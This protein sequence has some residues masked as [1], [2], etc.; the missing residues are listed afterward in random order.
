MLAKSLH[1][2]AIATTAVVTTALAAEQRQAPRFDPIPIMLR[3]V[4]DL[5]AVTG[6][7]YPSEGGIAEC[8]QAIRTWSSANFSGGAFTAQQGFSQGEIAAVSFSVAADQFPLRV[9]LAEM[10]FAT[11]SANVTTT[12]HWS[13]MFW[14]GTPATGQLIGT[15]SSDG[16]ILPHLVMPPGTNGTNIQ[17]SVD[18][19]DPEQ[20][21]LQNNGSGIVSVGYRIDKHH[22][23]PGGP[24]G[25]IPT[26][27][28]AFPTT[29]TNGLGA[30]TTNWLFAINCGPFACPAGWKSF[31]QLIS[32]CKPSGDWNI[33]LTY[34][35]LGCAPPT[36]GACCLPSGACTVASPDDCAAQSGTFQG[37]N[38]NCAGVTCL[39]TGNV[40]CCFPATGNC[41]NLSFA[42]CQLAGGVPG[43]I[44]LT[45]T[46]Y[47]CFPTGACCKPDGTCAVMSPGDCALASGLYQG[48]NTTC[49]QVNCP[50]PTGA[51]CFPNNF[52]LLM[53]QADAAAAGASWKGAGTTCADNNFNG[54]ADVCEIPAIPGDIN[55]DGFVNGADL[56][57][58]L[59]SWGPCGGCSGDV[60]GDDLVDGADIAIV[61]GNWTG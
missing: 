12:T 51:A 56:A 41:L 45:C 38:T 59:G 9:D 46:G 52:C 16:K 60:T 43:P 30:P 17:F 58:V 3:D 44:G 55:G 13:V 27:A 22:S 49:G 42:N 61:L 6:D 53:T 34:T 15:F 48:N 7:G 29:D 8:P 1:V 21:I 37:A 26:N 35:G 33:R 50:A 24:C 25:A 20:I 31:N 23:L 40:P 18:P 54:T 47:T 19:G 11:T 57:I 4:I 39:P 14:E 5:P 36:P 2:I 10:I 28:N 32:V